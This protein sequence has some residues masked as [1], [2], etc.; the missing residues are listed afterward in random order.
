MQAVELKPEISALRIFGGGC[1]YLG[2]QRKATKTLTD[3]LLYTLS[4]A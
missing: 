2:W 4:L 3:K 1:E